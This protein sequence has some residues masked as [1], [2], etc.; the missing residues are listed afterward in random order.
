MIQADHQT[1]ATRRAFAHHISALAGIDREN[2]LGRAITNAFKA[3]PRE[4]FLGPPPWRI[5]SPEGHHLSFSDKIKDIYKDVLVSLDVGKGL[6]NGQPSLHAF[7]L[8]A[9]V[10]REGERCVHVGAGTGYY[11]ALL[12][13]LVG[14]SGRIDAFEIDPELAARAAANLEDFGQVQTHARSG[15]EAP[16]PECD[17][18]Y[19][20]A[21]SAEPLGV[22]LDALGCGGRLLFPLEAE[23]E[24]GQMLLVSRNAEETYA[25]RLVCGVQ[26]VA[27]IGAQEQRATNAL[28]TAFKRGDSK[29]V[30]KLYRNDSPDDSCWC[31][32]K[33]W[34]LSTR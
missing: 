20:S 8:N 30:K 12:A 19:V 16:I 9:L 3:I 5:I 26:F 18:L 22:W 7:C 33:G 13:S 15:A 28:A 2:A 4:R 32:G 14:E 24:G 31:A 10:P 27:C 29:L 11:T 1:E 25:A 21:A 34:W 23:G 17:V 6:N